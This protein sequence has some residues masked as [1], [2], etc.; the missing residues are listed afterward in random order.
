M[1]LAFCALL[2]LGFTIGD[3]SRIAPFDITAI[4][5]NVAKASVLAATGGG[6]GRAGGNEEGEGG[7]A[8]G[9]KKHRAAADTVFLASRAGRGKI[10]LIH[11]EDDDVVPVSGARDL[12]GGSVS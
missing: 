3:D 8:A 5:A 7:V 10:L 9:N 6:E 4:V 1:L 12:L 2:Q 11:G